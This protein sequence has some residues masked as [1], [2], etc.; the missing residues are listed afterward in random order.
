[1]NH[2]HYIIVMRDTDFWLVGPFDTL[3]VAGEW[4]DDPANN[5]TDDPR[6]QTI[7]LADPSKPVRVLSPEQ[8][9]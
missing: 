7:K 4:G 2:N 1:M 8:A 5:P 3:D 9:A 6:W